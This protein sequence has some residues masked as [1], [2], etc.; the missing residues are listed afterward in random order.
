MLLGLKKF[1]AEELID[2]TLR[3]K[4]EGDPVRRANR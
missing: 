3:E 2:G 1:E 4:I